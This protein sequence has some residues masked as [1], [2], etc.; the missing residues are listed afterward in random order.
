[1]KPELLYY[2]WGDQRFNGK[3]YGMYSRDGSL[4]KLEIMFD[5]GVIKHRDW[6]CFKWLHQLF[7]GHRIEGL[8]HIGRGGKFKWDCYSKGRY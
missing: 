8:A 4:D 2:I 3:R 7:T 5:L 6:T 1:M